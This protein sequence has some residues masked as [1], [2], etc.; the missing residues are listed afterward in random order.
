MWDTVEQILTELPRPIEMERE[1]N[2]FCAPAPTCPIS[3]YLD[4]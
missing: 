4:I 1:C 2:N 3:S